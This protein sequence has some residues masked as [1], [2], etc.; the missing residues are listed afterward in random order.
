ME[1]RG[2]T[3]TVLT[4]HKEP[5]LCLTTDQQQTLLASGSEDASTRIWDLR[6]E[7]SVRC[8]IAGEEQVNS[9]CFGLDGQ[10]MFVANGNKIHQFDLRR[11]EIVLRKWEKEYQ[12]NTDEIN[13][14]CLQE[15]FLAS[16]DDSGEI[17]VI[18]LSDGNCKILR[19]AHKNICSTIR[20]V[21]NRNNQL[22]SGGLDSQ[23]IHW[24]YLRLKPIFRFELH[25]QNSGA[26]IVNPPFVHSIDINNNGELMAAG[27]GNHNAVVYNLPKHRILFDLEYH[28]S[29]VSKILFPSFRSN[30]VLTGSDDESL[31]LWDL[32]HITP[33]KSKQKEHS[34]ATPALTIKHKA[35][36]N[37]LATLSNGTIIVA[38]VTKGITL[39]KSIQ[40]LSAP[41]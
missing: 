3:S 4:G 38:D 27:L 32:P 20:F 9:I 40:V 33:S 2:T 24:D 26:Q 19:N 16:C 41:A 13:E 21:P 11:P 1:A 35:K 22:V 36:I 14:I 17:R 23:I 28:T 6:T 18:N 31:V 29:T 37:S 12:V 5:I 10:F 39:Y 7:K 30:Q 34:S 15:N 8:L 25:L